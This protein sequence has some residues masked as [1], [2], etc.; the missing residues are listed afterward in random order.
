[1]GP[2]LGNL[3]DLVLLPNWSMLARFPEQKCKTQKYFI[4]GH[5]VGD[6]SP[7]IDSLLSQQIEA[8]ATVL[9]VILGIFPSKHNLE[10]QLLNGSFRTGAFV[11]NAAQLCQVTL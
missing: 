9:S 2:Q 8:I 5:P 3:K 4:R 10:P 1:M 6:A 7:R 11:L